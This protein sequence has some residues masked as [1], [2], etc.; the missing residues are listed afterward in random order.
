MI[1]LAAQAS[2]CQSD[3]WTFDYQRA[4]TGYYQRS[5]TFLD[6]LASFS[7]LTLLVMLKTV[8]AMTYNGLNAALSL[9]SPRRK[10][11]RL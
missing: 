5:G 9:Y 2:I 7:A 6:Q 10:N 1:D 3:S 11:L 8:T 4:G